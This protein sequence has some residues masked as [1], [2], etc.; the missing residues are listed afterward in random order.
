MFLESGSQAESRWN[1]AAVAARWE[2]I[3]AT[4]GQL[5]AAILMT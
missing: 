2:A 3:G 5:S 4:T 1:L